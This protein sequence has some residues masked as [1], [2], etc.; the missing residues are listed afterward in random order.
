MSDIIYTYTD[1]AP[2]MATFSLFPIIKRFLKSANVDIEMMDISLA[3]RVLA[4][5]ADYLKPEQ[6]IP[7][8]LKILGDFVDN[9]SYLAIIQRFRHVEN[10]LIWIKKASFQARCGLKRRCRGGGKPH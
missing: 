6:Q 4:N 8:F 5:F 10:F 2:A 7:D 1:E 9:F 3:G